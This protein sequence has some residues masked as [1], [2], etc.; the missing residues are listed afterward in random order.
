MAKILFIESAVRTEKLGIMH[1]SAALKQAGHQTRLCWLEREDIHETMARF[2]PDYLAF[3]LM[4][5][6]HE[7]ELE[8][9][10]ELR[11]RY[12]VPVVVGGPHVTF[13]PAEIP[14]RSADYVVVGQGEQAMVDIVEGRARE[15]V[16]RYDLADLDSLPFPDRELFYRYPEFRD[17][18]MKNV[19]TCRDCPYSCTYCYNHAWKEKYK[20]QKH[21]L[22]KRSVGS[23]IAEI[24]EIKARY[25]LRQVIFIDDNFLLKRAWVEEFCQRYKRDVGLPFLCC[26]SLNLLDEEL[27]VRLKEAGLVMVNFALESADPVVQKTILNRGHIKN[28]QIIAAIRLLRRHKIK[29][30]M[31][32]IIGMPVPDPL[33]DA[34]NTLA[35]NRKHRVDDSWV[36]ILQPYPN[37]RLA[38]YCLEHGYIPGRGVSYAPSFFDHTCLDI[39]DTGKINRLQKW[40]YFAIKYNLPDDLLRWLLDVELPEAAADA[41]LRLRFEFSRKYLYAM[42]AAQGPLRHDGARIRA[43]HGSAPQFPVFWPVIAR[44]RLCNGLADI[45]MTLTPPAGHGQPPCQPKG[46]SPH[47]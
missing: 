20:S 22:Q 37:T 35:F 9:A 25:P 21:F 27:L 17:N 26:F 29:T 15:R 34:L 12:G 11:A 43:R 36:S 30:R 4:T 32:N 19:I 44:Y 18:P 6:S 7:A 13:F 24:L 31:Q 14:E 40:W 39:P 10:A 23:V 2:Q 33:K 1:V 28:D 3:S 46:E 5:G 47:A 42:P 16:L 38:D 41:L 45:L 8:L